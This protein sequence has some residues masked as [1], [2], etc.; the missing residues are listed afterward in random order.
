[1]LQ[2]NTHSIPLSC[3]PNLHFQVHAFFPAMTIESIVLILTFLLLLLMV[4]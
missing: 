2:G 4:N 3:E 1:M